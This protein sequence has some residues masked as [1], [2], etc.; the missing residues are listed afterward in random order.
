[1]DGC[2]QTIIK[3]CLTVP[4]ADVE[5]QPMK[6][7][8]NVYALPRYVEP[9]R[10]A[11][12]CA[13]VIDVLRSAT[14]IVHA[15]A[16]GAN[17]ILPCLEIEDARNLAR[18]FPAGEVLLGGEREGLPIEGFD[19]GN[20]PDEYYTERV[21]C[22]SIVLTTTNGTRAMDRARAAD[23][24]FIAAFV[25]ARAVA[26]RLF[27]RENVHIL[28]AGTDGK[29]SEDDVLLAGFFVERLLREGGAVYVQN[30]QAITAREMWLHAFALPQALGAEPLEADRLADRLRRSLGGQHLLALGLDEDILAASQ[31]DRFDIV[32]RLDPKTF[33]IRIEGLGI[34]D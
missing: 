18:Q 5:R 12:G 23:D 20:S 4:H 25:N 8:L 11:G 30:G 32:P 9:D 19:L 26:R 29:I 2:S 13:V 21:G 33:R 27:D 3:V 6:P 7:T 22:K 16:A 14:S 15:L 31:L 10:L 17:E 24:V 28:C 1:M 34:R